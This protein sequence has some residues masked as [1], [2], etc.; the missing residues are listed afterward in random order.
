RTTGSTIRDYVHVRDAA[1]ACL[2]LAECAAGESGQRIRE[3]H[4]RSGW[5]LSE[6][7]M[8]AAIQCVSSNRSLEVAFSEQKKNPLNWSPELNFSEAIADSLAVRGESARLP[9]LWNR[10]SEPARRTAA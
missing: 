4:F 5:L 3:E 6:R 10:T 1:R 2:L 7:D 8:A 9:F